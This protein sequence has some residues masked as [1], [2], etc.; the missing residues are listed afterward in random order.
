MK[1]KVKNSK[2]ASEKCQLCGVLVFSYPS[3]IPHIMREHIKG[4]H[5]IID[6]RI[7]SIE[8]RFKDFR[9]KCK[10][11]ILNVHKKILRRNFYVSL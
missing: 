3:D 7:C 5:P 9:E 6:D 8:K 1:E 4:K 10:K 11:D 2:N